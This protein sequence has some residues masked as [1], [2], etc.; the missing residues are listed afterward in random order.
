MIMNYN[1]L[2][3]NFPEYQKF[4]RKF[5]ESYLCSGFFVFD[6]ENKQET[7][8]LDFYIPKLNKIASL[9]IKT[10]KLKISKIME[11][12]K[13]K[14]EK[15][16]PQVKINPKSIK[17]LINEEIKKRKINLN[18]IKIIAVVSSIKS[19]TIWSINCISSDLSLIKIKISDQN[20]ETTEFKKTSMF[21]FVKKAK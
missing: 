10:G 11:D 13:I 9:D 19:Q 5:P 16:N 20:A 21:D 14:I 3:K 17:N 2:I 7:K 6:L 18:L 15:L 8:Q 1:F 12:K 4:R